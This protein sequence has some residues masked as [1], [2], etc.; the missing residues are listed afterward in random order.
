[1][2]S[3]AVSNPDGEHDMRQEHPLSPQPDWYAREPRLPVRIRPRGSAS[4]WWL[5]SDP[6]GRGTSIINYQLSNI[7]P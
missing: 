4:T 6:L 5:D 3:V 1:M 7:P 2:H